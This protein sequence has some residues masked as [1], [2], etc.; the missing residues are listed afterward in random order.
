MAIRNA[1]RLTS[2]LPL[3]LGG[4]R[5]L[6][7]SVYFGL[8]A[9][10]LLSADCETGKKCTITSQESFLLKALQFDGFLSSMLKHIDQRCNYFHAEEATKRSIISD[11]KTQKEAV[12]SN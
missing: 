4:G 11:E 10:S 6:L 2:I 3:F 12:I 9:I 1:K 5:M 7:L 8:F